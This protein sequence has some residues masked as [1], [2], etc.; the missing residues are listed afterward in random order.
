MH[1]H[2]LVERSRYVPPNIVG[3]DRQ[4]P[5]ASI[6]QDGKLDATGPPEIIESVHC[7]P[8]GSSRVQHV[9]DQNNRPSLDRHGDARRTHDR[10]TTS[11]QIVTIQADVE[12]SDR[13]SRSLELLNEVG[14][15]FGQVNATRVNADDHDVRLAHVPFE[16]LMGDTDEGATHLLA[17]EHLS[18]AC[19]RCFPYSIRGRFSHEKTLLPEVAEGCS[20]SSI[21]RMGRYRS[22]LASLAGLL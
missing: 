20:R 3:A 10:A 2:L 12:L 17:V 13:R 14:C 5:V 9:V 21:R 11:A 6:D 18:T 7:G 1:S 15:P 4:L 16:D 8:H 19:L 22:R